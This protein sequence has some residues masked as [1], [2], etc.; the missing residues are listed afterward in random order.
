MFL[1][2]PLLALILILFLLLILPLPPPSFPTLE[3][4]SATMFLASFVRVRCSALFPVAERLSKTRLFAGLEPLRRDAWP[5]KGCSVLRPRAQLEYSESRL[6][7]CSEETLRVRVFNNEDGGE[8]SSWV[9]SAGCVCLLNSFVVVVR[10]KD[11]N[12]H[13]GKRSHN[14]LICMKKGWNFALSTSLDDP[15][16]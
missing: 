7:A 1:Y 5:G 14:T 2:N 8:V 13:D 6:T 15:E 9:E 11:I 3:I 10:Q 16:M 12:S 4:S